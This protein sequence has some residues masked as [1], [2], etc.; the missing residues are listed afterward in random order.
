MSEP[1]DSLALQYVQNSGETVAGRIENLKP[2]PKGVSGNPGGR[3]KRDLSSEIAQAVFEN[4]PEAIY[5]AMTRALCKGDARVF[6]GAG[7]S[8]LRKNQGNR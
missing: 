6:K 8:S 4:N 3:P 1:S 2:W 5:R 7:R